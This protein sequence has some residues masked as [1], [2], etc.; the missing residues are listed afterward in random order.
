[1]RGTA[2]KRMLLRPD[3]AIAL[4]A[5][6]ERGVPIQRA[7]KNLSLEC[8]R[9]TIAKLLD[10]MELSEIEAVTA[11]LNPEWLDADGEPIQTQPDGWRYIGRFPLGKWEQDS[12]SDS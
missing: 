7:M 11:S 5:D 2:A 4:K 6:V 9:P 3:V 12:C 1:M 8:S 10:T